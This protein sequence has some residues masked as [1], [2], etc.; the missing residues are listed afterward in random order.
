MKI[1]LF[2]FRIVVLFFVM[3]SCAAINEHDAEMLGQPSQSVAMY[4]AQVQFAHEVCGIQVDDASESERFVTM[5]AQNGLSI[6]HYVKNYP[7]FVIFLN[8]FTDKY[9]ARWASLTQNEMDEF[10]QRYSADVEKF[11]TMRVIQNSIDFRSHFSPPTDEYVRKMENRAVVGGI[12]LGAIS[13]GS[14]IEG[15]RETNRGN[16]TRAQNRFSTTSDVGQII[17]GASTMT[18]AKFCPAYRPFMNASAPP[19]DDVWKTYHSIQHC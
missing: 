7:E 15:V 5:S 3:A 4:S 19:R 10:C 16:F 11:R 1:C 2:N 18:E 12:V 9:R 17:S 8:E 13:A 6:S 14:A